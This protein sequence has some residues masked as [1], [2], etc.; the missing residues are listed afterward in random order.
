MTTADTA[1]L[2][3]VALLAALTINTSVRQAPA[4]SACVVDRIEEGAAPGQL[5]AILEHPDTTFTTHPAGDI[6]GAREGAAV[7]CPR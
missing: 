2:A 1:A 3:A 4:P 7:P 6:P 5:W